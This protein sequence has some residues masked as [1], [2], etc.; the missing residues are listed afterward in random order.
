MNQQTQGNM[1]TG[2]AAQRMLSANSPD[3]SL[4]L[5]E[6]QWVRAFSLL[7]VAMIMCSCIYW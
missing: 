2:P 3:D 7:L 1:P 6:L 5:G 4:F